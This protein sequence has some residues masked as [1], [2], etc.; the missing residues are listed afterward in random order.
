M[1]VQDTWRFRSNMTLDYGVRYSLAPALTDTNNALVTF[2]RSAFV[3]G[4]GPTCANAA[5]TAL[6]PNTGNPLNGL[7]VAGVNS[8][9]GRSIYATDKNNIQPR[10]GFSW[11]PM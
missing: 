4:G 1:F 7:I 9:Y 3:P 2:D 10:V 8:P 6:L 11:D 5:C